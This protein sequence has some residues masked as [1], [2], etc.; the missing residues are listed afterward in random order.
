MG[1]WLGD[2]RFIRLWISAIAWLAIAE[3]GHATCEFFSEPQRYNTETTEDA[4]VIGY[5]SDRP[6]RVVLFSTDR[7]T[8]DEVRACVLDAFVTRSRLGS[9]IQIASFDRRDDAETISRILRS[10]GYRARVVYRR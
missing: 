3:A 6:Y 7:E 4:I 1:G 10:S 5:R 9:Y 8:L 2:R